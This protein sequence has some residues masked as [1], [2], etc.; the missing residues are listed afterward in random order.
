MHRVSNRVRPARPNPLF[1]LTLWLD[2]F[3]SLLVL[4]IASLVSVLE[5]MSCFFL[6]GRACLEPAP[7]GCACLMADVGNGATACLEVVG[8][9]VTQPF[10][11]EWWAGVRP[12]TVNLY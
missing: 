1:S 2:N 4:A 3:L 11:E 5:K 12:T 8:R 10:L 7:S 9:A 6:L